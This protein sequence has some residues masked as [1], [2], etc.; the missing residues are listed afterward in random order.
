MAALSK[1]ETSAESTMSFSTMYRSGKERL[2]R[3]GG[4]F[5]WRTMAEWMNRAS[6]PESQKVSAIA[7]SNM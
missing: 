4:M 1:P 3:F 6:A 5:F 7:S 2:D